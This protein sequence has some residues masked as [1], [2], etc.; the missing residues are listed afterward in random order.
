MASHILSADSQASVRMERKLLERMVGAGALILALILIGPAILDGNRP[1][2]A[3][4]DSGSAGPAPEE[5]QTRT[6]RLNQQTLNRAAPSAATPATATP[7]ADSGPGKPPAVIPPGASPATR[8]EP[9]RAALPAPI[10]VANKPADKTRPDSVQ[11]EQT[12]SE[13]PPSAV[14]ERLGVTP[15]NPPVPESGPPASG[16]GW[17]VQLG[18]FGQQDNAERLARELK[19]QGFAAFVSPQTHSGKTL[20]RVR[21]GPEDQRAA[22][23]DL[24]RRLTSAGHAGSVVPM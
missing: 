11:P 4:V 14:A 16:S 21:V 13:L 7:P 15:A 2:R 18:S 3:T 6:I 1:G 22:A 24:A 8:P 17:G 20:Y 10:S 23:E 19:S 9:A 5:L 12:R